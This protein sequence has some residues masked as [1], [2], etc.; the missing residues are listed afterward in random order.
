[1]IKDIYLSEL[2]RMRRQEDMAVACLTKFVERLKVDTHTLDAFLKSAGWVLNKRYLP[3]LPNIAYVAHACLLIAERR[4]ADL[5]RISDLSVAEVR[6]LCRC[7]DIVSHDDL[8]KYDLLGWYQRF[9]AFRQALNPADG[10]FFSGGMP[11][12][13]LAAAAIEEKLTRL[14][15]RKSPISPSRHVAI[16]K[17]IDDDM[18]IASRLDDINVAN[19]LKA[20]AEALREIISDHEAKVKRTSLADWARDSGRLDIIAEWHP[21]R[22]AITP[23]QT[24]HGTN[25]TVWWLCGNGHETS[26]SLGSRIYHAGRCIQC[27]KKARIGRPIGRISLADWAISNA[28]GDLITEW[29]PDNEKSPKD[30]PYGSSAKVFW[31]CGHNHRWVCKIYERT[32]QGRVCPCL[33]NKVATADN[34]FAAVHPAIAAEWCHAKNERPPQSYRPKSGQKVWWHCSSCRHEWQACINSRTGGQNSGCPACAG[35]VATDEINLAV[36]RP[37][38]A[39]DWSP[40]NVRA[41]R[42]YRPLSNEKVA[43]R[44]GRCHHDWQARISSRSSGEGCP[45]CHKRSVQAGVYRRRR[46]KERQA[47]DNVE[48]NPGLTKGPITQPT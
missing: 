33:G 2:D 28:R 42:S 29:H 31:L 47:A 12:Y 38:L 36:A 34:N 16:R 3:Y 46:K 4:V 9:P 45:R 41:P 13:N 10:A 19:R 30:Y 1:M 17:M 11:I 26:S 15:V 8:A 40:K 48:G 32:T 18:S 35:R 5:A 6:V 14:L 44:C 21:T 43:W 27:S 22:N 23:D 25:V 7:F 39:A 20:A 37:D 24:S